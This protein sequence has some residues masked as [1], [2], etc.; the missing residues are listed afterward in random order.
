MFD[1]REVLVLQER[2]KDFLHQAARHRLIHQMGSPGRET[3]DRVIYWALTWLGRH[4]VAWGCFLETR[5]AP[6]VEA[7]AAPTV[8]RCC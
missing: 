6:R 5:Y 3:R 2:H 1:W 8:K 7:P 4:L